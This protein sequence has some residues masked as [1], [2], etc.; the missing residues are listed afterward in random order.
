[1]GLGKFKKYRLVLLSWLDGN[2][3]VPCLSTGKVPV[4]AKSV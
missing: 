4:D 1:V 3:N 2:V